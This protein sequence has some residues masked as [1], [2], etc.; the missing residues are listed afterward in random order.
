VLRFLPISISLRN[1]E[2]AF[3]WQLRSACAVQISL[4]FLGCITAESII[5]E[6]NTR[7]VVPAPGDD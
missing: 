7:S 2:T 3:T 1:S 5:T 4:N 6:A